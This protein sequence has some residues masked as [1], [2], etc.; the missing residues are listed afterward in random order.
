MDQ[1]MEPGCRCLLI[2][3]LPL[4]DHGEA[5]E[6]V[7]RHTPEIPLWV[8]LPRR[9]QEGMISQFLPGMP[10]LA[11]AAGNESIRTDGEDFDEAALRATPRKNQSPDKW[12]KRC[13]V[14]TNTLE[15]VIDQERWI[16]RFYA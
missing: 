2:G 9:K 1:S 7:L 14:T 10:G 12:K 16:E 3:S 4:D 5:L 8:Q 15:R 11:G 6:L 13:I